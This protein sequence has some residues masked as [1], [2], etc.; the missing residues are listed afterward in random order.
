LEIIRTL[1]IESDNQTEAEA[2]RSQ[3]IGKKHL[4]LEARNDNGGICYIALS[5]EYSGEGRRSTDWD[6]LEPGETKFYSAP[7]DKKIYY[8]W[9]YGTKANDK[10]RLT[11]SDGAIKDFHRI[12]NKVYGNFK[13]Y[14]L[15]AQLGNNNT[16]IY[17]L[18]VPNGK[19][20]LIYWGYIY[21]KDNV[22]RT[23]SCDLVK[24]NGE[25][26]AQLVYYENLP[27]NQK[28][29]F[30]SKGQDTVLSKD[31]LS[32]HAYPIIAFGG[33]YLHFIWNAGGASTGGTTTFGVTIKELI[34]VDAWT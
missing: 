26:K 2:K 25:A 28:V 23:V 7:K 32:G 34:D 27:S 4:R 12:R 24:P 1:Y 31:I 5:Y 8:V 3:F 10:I 21:N 20:W 15:T 9:Y 17:D 11:A 13:K 19:I 33:D 16:V 14:D 18:I 6:L 29:V 30:P 22:S